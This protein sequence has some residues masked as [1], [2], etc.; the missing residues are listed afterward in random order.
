[1]DTTHIK[2]KF[3]FN[4][5]NESGLEYWASGGTLLGAIRHKDIIPWDDDIDLDVFDTI[6]NNEKILYMEGYL[7]SVGLSLCKTEWGYKI[8]YTEGKKISYNPW[9]KHITETGKLYPNLDR[10]SVVPMAKETYIKPKNKCYYEWRFPSLDLFLVQNVS[11]KIIYNYPE[12]FYHDFIDL[13]P[14]QDAEFGEVKIK[15]PFKPFPYLYRG[16]GEKCMTV[17]KIYYNH[18]LEKKVKIKYISI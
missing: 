7:N 6:E 11:N 14:L 4:I 2:L 18:E 13:Y 3:I 15:I 5:I 1:M 10:V 16:Y 9:S 8:Y 17:G 12:K